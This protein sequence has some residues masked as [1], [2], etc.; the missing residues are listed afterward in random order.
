[1]NEHCWHSDGRVLL[2]HPP[3]YPMTCC[4]CGATW[5]R[6]YH[7]TVTP[8]H[9]PHAGEVLERRE[10][11]YDGP[12]CSGGAH[13]PAPAPTP[14]EVDA[15]PWKTDVGLPDWHRYATCGDLRR[16]A[17]SPAA[18]S[19][20]ATARPD[21]YRT[22]A[23]PPGTVEIRNASKFAVATFAD[24]VVTVADAPT[25]ARVDRDGLGRIAYEAAYSDDPLTPGDWPKMTEEGDESRERFCRAAEAVAAAVL[26][27]LTARGKL[28]RTA[29]CPEC[30]VDGTD[31]KLCETCDGDGVVEPH[32]WCEGC[33]QPIHEGDEYAHGGEDGIYLC[34][35]CSRDCDAMAGPASTPAPLPLETSAQEAV[36]LPSLAEGDA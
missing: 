27:G 31:P 2:T 30:S 20:P 6:R 26:G 18:T 8:G 25:T 33:E 32:A 3:Q 21:V 16:G 35:E 34:A 19:S 9:G 4:H 23:P 28:A 10:V 12:A 17:P 1:M 15:A 24:G 11:P 36:D 13:E 7:M 22:D 14:G 29:P 5:T